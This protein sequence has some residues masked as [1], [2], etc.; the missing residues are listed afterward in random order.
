MLNAIR[1]IGV[2]GEIR[3][4]QTNQLDK[5]GREPRWGWQLILLGDH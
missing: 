4:T 2:L 5:E 1:N 3:A